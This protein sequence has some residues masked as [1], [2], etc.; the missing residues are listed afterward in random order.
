[1]RKAHLIIGFVMVYIG[2]LNA[3]CTLNTTP[4]ST[5]TIACG[6][7]VTLSTFATG[8]TPLLTT[9]FDLGGAGPGWTSG[10]GSG[11]GQLCGP[12]ANNT[13][14]YWASTAGAG[15]PQLTTVGFDL[16]CGGFVSFD[17]AY[18]TQG[19]ATPCEGP[20]LPDEGVTFQYST[21]GGTTWTTIQYWDPNGGN[22]PM[23]TAWNNYSFAIP[24]AAQSASTMFRWIQFNS[25]GNCCDNWGLDNVVITPGLCSVGSYDWSN[26]PGTN[27]PTTQDVIPLVSTQYIVTYTDGPVSCEDTVDVIVTPLVANATT[28][29]DSLT[30]L[31]CADLDVVLV[32]SNAGSIVDD[33]DPVEDP[34]MWSN[35][36]GG[37]VGG[38][39]NSMSGTA[40]YFNG[41]GTRAITTVPIDAT[42]CGFVDFCL[43]M[44]NVNSGGSPCENADAG[45]DIIFQYSING[46]ATWITINTYAQSLW[47]ANNNWQCFTLPIPPPA[48]TINTMFQWSQ[49]S[50][51]G[52]IDNWSIDNVSIACAPPPYDYVWTPSLSLDD[53]TIQT[54]NACPGLP[55]IYT[56]TI[57]D[58]ASGC[59][60]SDTTFID[61]VCGCTF[62][63]FNANTSACQVGN[64]FTV[65]GDFTYFLNPGTGSIIV[66]VINGSGT[67]TQTINPPFV[68]LT[69]YNFAISGIPS[70]GSAYTATIYFTDDLTCTTQATG[71][72]PVIPTL[73][74]ILGGG[75][76]C[77]ADV[78]N[79]ITVDVTGTGPW[80]IDYTIDG[81]PFNATGTT[82]TV[83]LGNTP[84]VYALVNVSDSSCTNTATGTE[85]ITIQT[86]P[87]VT[88]LSGGNNYCSG[89]PISSILADV[90]GLG[91]WTINYTLDGVA[92]TVTSA[93]SPL[94]LGNALG[95][96][97]LTS[98][99]DANCNQLIT[100]TETIAIDP[101]P[102]VFAGQD[103]ILCEGND[104]VLS[105]SG[106]SSYVWDNGVTNNIPFVPSSTA[107]YT[108]IGTDVNGCT[109]M[110]QI[111]IT[112]EPLPVVSF[113]ADTTVIC[114]GSTVVFTNTTPGNLT[115]CTWDFGNGDI[116]NE[117]DTINTTY[118]SSGFFNVMLRTTSING[119]SNSLTQ[120]AFIYVE[121][122][123]IAAFSASPQILLA[124]NTDVSFSNESVGST[125]YIWDFGDNSPT[126]SAENPSHEFPE[127]SSGSYDVWLYAESPIGCIDS[128]RFVIAI[129]QEVIYYVPNTF[130]P[131]GDGF[132]QTFQPVFTDGFDPYDFNLFI[133]NRWGE[134]IWESHDASIGWDGTY[135]GKTVQSGTYVWKIEFKTIKNDERKMIT[136]HVNLIR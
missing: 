67:F 35:V 81:V 36:Q 62:S 7:T 48:Q 98:I 14:Y 69:S 26:L 112:H 90:S 123:P 28:T 60:A 109:G 86:N 25:S 126:S 107:T 105:G 95:V 135:N 34:A 125:D 17:M 131:D 19:G 71:T 22:D 76:Y 46:G 52:T 88:L 132:N 92:N 64:T 103:S 106:A 33:F 115:D 53:A 10:G 30:C 63:V 21:D 20:D 29:V 40:M 124:F 3:Q 78:V 32:N 79:D 97:S 27:D 120:P 24:V 91:P 89:E 101:S 93:T 129:E 84:G 50:F 128:V 99:F 45:E 110:D 130:T 55:T 16:S 108:V 44:G 119:C 39:C 134:M 65:S 8:S 38:G 118:N 5:I 1:M 31:D 83:N 54:P 42:I 127:N 87:D 13:P 9:D 58:P 133:F 121:S 6:Q 41:S 73:T 56:A 61:V 113:L 4:N 122:I 117:C 104:I 66:E 96:Y 116:A 68:D 47:D 74:A 57:T 72:S 85:T 94:N 70:D 51:S 59:S 102:I 111:V 75:I 49:V 15:T 12:G 11:F 82:T 23:L 80:N 114:D 100:G 37:A 136:G 18:S 43:F 2:G 77:P